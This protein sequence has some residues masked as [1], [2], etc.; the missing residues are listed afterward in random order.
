[1]AKMPDLKLGVEI[2]SAAMIRPGDRLVLGF[3]RQLD[4]AEADSVAKLVE[5][6]LPGVNVTIIDGLANMA[7]YRPPEAT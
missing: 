4:M 6:R 7:A 3:S 2:S 5:E 1:M